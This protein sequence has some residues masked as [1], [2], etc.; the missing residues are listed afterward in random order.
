LTSLGEDE[1]AP[2]ERMSLPQLIE[3]VLAPHRTGERTIDVRFAGPGGRPPPIWRKPAILYGLGNIIE[4]AVDFADTTVEIEARWDDRAIVIAIRD[5]GPGISD[6]VI[7][8]LGD[9]YVTTRGGQRLESSGGL[10]LGFFI[11]KTLLE[12]T[13]A[14]LTVENRAPAARGASVTVE[15]PRAAIAIAEAADRTAPAEPDMVA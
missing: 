8:R 4:N 6:L 7:D 10:G 3:E 1:G 14:R 2:I 9:P 15:W 5:D 12:R 11:A 13:G